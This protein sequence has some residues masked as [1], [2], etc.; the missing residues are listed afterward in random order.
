MTK[1]NYI[2]RIK[3]TDDTYVS[4]CFYGLRNEIITYISSLFNKI[5]RNPADELEVLS[6][7]NEYQIN[8]T[9]QMIKE[10]AVAQRINLNTM[11]VILSLF[12]KNDKIICESH[13]RVNS[14]RNGYLPRKQC[15]F[16]KTNFLPAIMENPNRADFLNM[17]YHIN[18]TIESTHSLYIVCPDNNENNQDRYILLVVRFDTKQIY[19]FDPKSNP[20]QIQ[21]QFA[22]FQNSL[23]TFL[24]RLHDTFNG[25]WICIAH[26]NITYQ[27][28]ENDFDCALYIA[29]AILLDYYEVPVHLY[30]DMM[31]RARLKFSHWLLCGEI[32]I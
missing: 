19:C 6:T 26:P 3:Q 22:R 12:Q 30:I 23:N 27:L 20:N 18:N 4:N 21:A 17:F 9:L 16:T 25:P 32:I 10:F 28:L 1:P 5:I 8:V 11:D 15:L 2:E 14:E 31:E 29:Y 7:I 24:P 13:S